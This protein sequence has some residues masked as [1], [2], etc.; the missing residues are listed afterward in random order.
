MRGIILAG[1]SG[2]RLGPVARAINK[3][4]VPIYDKPMIY[5]PLT[6]LILAGITE[7]QLL[8]TSQAIPNFKS[9][10]GD[11]SQWGVKI[12]YCTQDAPTGIAGGLKIAAQEIGDKEPILVI[13]GDNIFFGQ[14]LGRSISEVSSDGSCH[15]WTQIVRDP[16][17]FGIAELNTKGQVLR[18]IE[19]PSMD[20]GS[21]AVTGLYKFPSG[22]LSK[23]DELKPSMRNELEITDVLEKY[24]KASKLT[25]HHLARSVYWLDAGTIESLG[26]MSQFVRAVQTRQGQLIGSPDEA[27]FQMGLISNSDLATLIHQLPQSDYRVALSKVLKN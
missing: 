23:L 17:N 4:L 6:T 19:K 1:G 16:E 2:T 9:L 12:S 20:I 11:G 22:V 25:N 8:S 26:E 15:I 21:N 18:I 5:Y 10:L 27:A 3:H 7:I 14:G 24:L 13:L